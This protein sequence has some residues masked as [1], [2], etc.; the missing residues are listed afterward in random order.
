MKPAWILGAV[1]VLTSAA[2]AQG[3]E[4][5]CERLKLQVLPDTTIT[6]VEFVPAGPYSPPAAP[7]T[8]AAAHCT[9]RALPDRGDDQ[10]DLR[11][12]HPH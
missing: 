9:A 4:E 8:D 12:R 1:C 5:S 7:G 11:F 2:H 6:A 3:D 10:A